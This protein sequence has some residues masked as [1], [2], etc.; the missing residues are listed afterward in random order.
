M[1][2]DGVACRLPSAS[3]CVL[4]LNLHVQGIRPFDLPVLMD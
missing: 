4:L 3:I 2:R 1:F